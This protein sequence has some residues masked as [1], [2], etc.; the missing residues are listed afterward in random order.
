MGTFSRRG[1]TAKRVRSLERTFVHN[2][3]ERLFDVKASVERMFHHSGASWCYRSKHLFERS[4]R[5]P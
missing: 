4:R 1:V 2:L 3:A 5:P